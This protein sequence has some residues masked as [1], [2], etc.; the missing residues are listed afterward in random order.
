MR[1]K[2]DD[3]TKAQIC[4]ERT[5]GKSFGNLAKTFKLP[6]STVVK[7]VKSRNMSKKTRGRKPIFQK[8]DERRLKSL[9]QNNLKDG[10]RTTSTSVASNL[11]FSASKST[12]CRMLRYLK[13]R[14]GKVTFHNTLSQKYRHLRIKIVR[15]YI[16]NNINWKD[17]VFSD[18]KRFN[19]DGCDNCNTWGPKTKYS[20]K[21]KR[22]LKSPGVMVW[23]MVMSNGLISYKIMHGRQ[24]STKYI[25]ILNDS[26]IKIMNLNY[27]CKIVFQQDNAPI[28]SSRLT[29]EF[30]RTSGIKPIEWPPY[31]PDLNIMENIWSM[32]QDVV[33][34]FKKAR[35]LKELVNNIK[36]AVHVLN[37]EKREEIKSLFDSVP[38]RF[39]DVI[40]FG[41]RK[42]K[43]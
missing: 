23:G 15:K 5:S 28:H 9:V 30:L 8:H 7:I 12:V 43:Y 34:K 31:S 22:I 21:M 36:T 19:L 32:L 13:F 27:K 33:Y 25:E 29:R 41:G 18:E 24:N 17:I 3:A 10:I 35:N 20:R 38:K 26:A 14:Y 2:I 37:T 40:A 1:N 4:N 42:L 11:G 16:E 39:C 6:K